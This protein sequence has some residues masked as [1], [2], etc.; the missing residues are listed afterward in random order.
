MSN[1]TFVYVTY[2]ATTPAKLW[3]ALLEGEITRQYWDNHQNVSASGWKE[4]DE[5]QHVA[6]ADAGSCPTDPGA[7]TVRITGKVLE[8]V[9]EKRLAL[10]WARPD[11]AHDEAMVTRVVIDIETVGDSVQLTV[12]HD[13]LYPEMRKGITWGWPRVLASMK[14]YLE[15]GRVLKVYV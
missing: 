10:T 7:G 4:G 14:S 13:K 9:P 5:W 8:F 6:P 2:I 11:K 12:T 15:T 3:Q 1:D